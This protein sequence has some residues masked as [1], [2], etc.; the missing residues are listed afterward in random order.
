MMTMRLAAIL[1]S[2][3]LVSGFASAQT[4]TYIYVGPSL[5]A[6]STDEGLAFTHKDR[7][8]SNR[9]ESGAGGMAS[10][11]FQSLPFGQAVVDGGRYGFTGEEQ[12]S[13]LLHYIGVRMYDSNVGRF[14]RIDPNPGEPAFQYTQNNPLRFT[15]PTGMTAGVQEATQAAA[16]TAAA[17]EVGWLLMEQQMIAWGAYGSGAT[18]A[19][20]A[21]AGEVVATGAGATLGA[22][23]AGAVAFVGVLL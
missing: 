16:G 23:F 9:V 17:A 4:M 18:A 14:T 20:S 5:V 19:T 10:L 2:L 13:S 6:T 21:G 22:I 11:P 12:D 7:L 15:D 1:I 8:G 3:L